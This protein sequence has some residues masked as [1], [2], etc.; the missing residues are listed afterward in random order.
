MRAVA[1]HDVEQDAVGVGLAQHLLADLEVDH[2]VRAALRVLLLA[3]VVDL[4]VLAE[5]RDRLVRERAAREEP[6]HA[7]L[8]ALVER[9]RR[10]LGRRE[11]AG[12]ERRVD[13]ERRGRAVPADERGHHPLAAD[14]DLAQLLH[15]LG[16]RRLGDE[17]QRLG[18][19][20]VRQHPHR[21]AEH[22]PADVRRQVAPADA[23]DLRHADAGA[24]EQDR[25]LL[26]AGPGGGHDPDRA[27]LDHVHE[28]QAD[29]AEHRRA[30]LRA[31]HQQAALGAA[32]LERDLVVHR[33]VVREQEDV[34]AGGQRAVRLERRVLARAPRS[35]RRSRRSAAA[36]AAVRSRRG[37]SPAGPPAPPRPRPAPRLPHRRR[38][39]P[40]R[41]ATRRHRRRAPRGSPPSPSRRRRGSRRRRRAR[42]ARPSSAARCPRSGCG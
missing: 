20:V 13:L 32:L 12:L 42:A 40:R 39:S 18:L 30:A 4:G 33:H 36:S 22:D 25:D 38:R 28:A 29:A 7:A 10:A 27:G 11:R 17:Q 9:R 3:E 15:R 37:R 2:R 21:L 5:D 35:A 23:D 6:E 8:G 1:E 16:R 41:S 31:H 34:H 19:V 26:R 14:V 24:I